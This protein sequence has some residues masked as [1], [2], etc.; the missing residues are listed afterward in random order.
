MDPES[1]WVI[2]RGS[3]ISRAERGRHLGM[4]LRKDVG[5]KGRRQKN[6][7]VGNLHTRFRGPLSPVADLIA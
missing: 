2:L 3:I 5:S 6:H 4:V 1:V 7:E